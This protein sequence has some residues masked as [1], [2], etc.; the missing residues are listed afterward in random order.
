MEHQTDRTY[1]STVNLIKVED[2]TSRFHLYSKLKLRPIERA[3]VQE[4]DSVD[5]I[6]ENL[7]Y[8]RGF[9]QPQKPFNL[10]TIKRRSHNININSFDQIISKSE[11]LLIDNSQIIEKERREKLHAR[12]QSIHLNSDIQNST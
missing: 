6:D 10:V 5:S 4:E 3:S 7:L 11:K 8:K 9:R 2:A 1:N 12:I